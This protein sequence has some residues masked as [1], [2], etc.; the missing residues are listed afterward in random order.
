MCQRGQKV[1][2]FGGRDREGEFLTFG[3]RKFRKNLTTEFE[4][5]DGEGWVGRG[6]P[7]DTQ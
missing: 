2:H 5:P 4:K 7:E 6:S 3:I 1:F